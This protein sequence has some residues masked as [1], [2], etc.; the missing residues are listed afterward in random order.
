MLL[1]ENEDEAQRFNFTELPPLPSTV[2]WGIDEDGKCLAEIRE[3]MKLHS[4]ALPVFIIYDSFNRV[5]HVQQGYTINL[6]EQLLK[7][8]IKIEN[9]KL[10]IED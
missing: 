9:S 10:K 4:P 8:I 3:Q 1:F 7:T 5:L 2:E 6:G